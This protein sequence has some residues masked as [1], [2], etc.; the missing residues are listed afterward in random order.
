MLENSSLKLASSR[1]KRINQ[2][3]KGSKTSFE[4]GLIELHKKDIKNLIKDN[5]L[6]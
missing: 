1:I 5:Q 4:Q 3:T 6:K 2:L